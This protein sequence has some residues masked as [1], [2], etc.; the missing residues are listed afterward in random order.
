MEIEKC[1]PLDDETEVLEEEGE[2]EK[3]EPVA[4]DEFYK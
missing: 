3:T 4:E 2:E 1:P